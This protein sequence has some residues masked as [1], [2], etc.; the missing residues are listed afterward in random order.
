[1]KLREYQ[2]P[3]VNKL[4]RQLMNSNE[5]AL[6]SAVGTGKTLVTAVVGDELIKRG[7]VKKVIVSAP[8]NTIVKEFPQYT[9]KKILT[10]NANN[11][12]H[13]IGNIE[14]SENITHVCN[15]ILGGSTE[16]V[17]TSHH[18]M[19]NNKVKTAVNKAY[20]LSDLLLVIDEAHHC[21]ESDDEEDNSDGTLLGAIANKIK[22]KGG[23]ILYVTATPYRTV[24]NQTN[25]IFDP[26]KCKPVI[27]TIGEQMRDGYAPSMNTEY[28][29]VKDFSLTNA[30]DTGLFGDGFN[31]KIS[32][33]Q[34]H[35]LLPRIIKQWKTEG[36][37]K[38]ILLVPAGNA[39]HSASEVKKCIESIKFP[40]EI[41]KIRG[42]KYPSVL[43]SVGSSNTIITYDGQEMN[44]IEYDK[45][46]NGHAYD[47]VVGC[48]K[49][50]E[51]TDVSSA[52]HLYMVGLPSSVRLFHQRTGRVLRNKKSID[53]YAEWFGEQW[54]NLSKVVFF[55][56]VG[57]KT[58]D[59]DYKVGR[60]LLHCIF[61]AESYQE[62][63]E[64][65]N[66]SQNIRIAFEDK[67][68][69][70]KNEV[71]REQLDNIMTV[72]SGIELNELKDYS[73][74]E[75]DELVK[76][77][78]HPDMTIGE[79]LDMIK[80][81]SL[82]DEQRVIALNNLINHLPDDIKQNID[83]DKVVN[84][85][86]K[87]CKPKKVAGFDVAPIAVISSELEQVL[88]EF[89]N[90]KITT[91]KEKSI[92]KVFSELSGETLQE[93]AEKCSK[94]MGE[95]NAIMMCNKV[96]E[97]CNYHNGTYPV[98]KSH[99]E[100]EKRIGTWLRNMRSIKNGNDGCKGNFYPSLDKLA[101]EAGY[102]DM[103][104]LIDREQKAIQKI[105]EICDFI[106]V[107]NR[108]PVDSSSNDNERYLARALQGFRQS[109]SGNG[110]LIWYDIVQTIANSRGYS[111]IL[112]FIDD[113][114]NA[115]DITIAI[116]EFI[117]S[118]GKSPS[119][120][121]KNGIERK[122]GQQLT[123]MKKAKKGTGNRRIFYASVQ[124]KAIELGYPTLF[125]LIDLNETAN[126]R[127]SDICD[128]IDSN[129]RIPSNKS[130][131]AH[132][133]ALG[134]TL[135]NWKTA[136]KGKQSS[137][138]LYPSVIDIFT[139]RGYP[140]VLNGVD[141]EQ[142]ALDAVSEICDFIDIYKT[143]PVNSTNSRLSSKLIALRRAKYEQI[144]NGIRWYDS[145]QSLVESRGY[146]DMFNK[147]DNQQNAIDKLMK[148]IGFYKINNRLPTK[149]NIDVV[150]NQLGNWIQK[151]RKAKENN[152]GNSRLG[153]F[154]PILDSICADNGIPDLFNRIDRKQYQ[155]NMCTELIA[156]IKM[157]N[158]LPSFSSTN[159][160]EL[161]LARWIGTVRKGNEYINILSK[162]TSEV[163]YPN[164]FN[165][166]WKD[167][168][169]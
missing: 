153:I 32:D 71:T 63:C 31:T 95:D 15:L 25:L 56:P 94:F 143:Y 166:H 93:W 158:K 80:S 74:N 38:T 7:I 96:I 39:E 4:I 13:L 67:A 122:L 75:F 34:L 79:R 17:S 107:N 6:V 115:I 111:D 18:A 24:G 140:D 49:F 106:D 84:S 21:F 146:P 121:S 136:S 109:K 62:Y 105:T 98:Q 64:S 12:Q 30:G 156:H 167:D 145:I 61:A 138:I 58:K 144:P 76:E 59:F 157:Y 141:S 163:G 73:D 3:Q 132:E 55:A 159:K 103:F 23:K 135:S 165:K 77:S 65:M 130:S 81:A 112:N 47:I 108:T 120:N 151:Q 9:G 41:V 104:S 117:N 102:P 66:A 88:E 82:T 8:F 148:V 118:T 116:C 164:L 100:D 85:I 133:K 99:D 168:V 86:V 5:A 44:E 128:F 154:Y 142:R 113:E 14:K 127:A 26:L 137:C 1:M 50:D 68:K 162:M 89:C 97:F 139:S 123:D 48:R 70:E 43:I 169:K 114:Q 29:H 11:A 33:P 87:S 155:I 125:E 119:S 69:K 147:N 42:R 90:Q 37:P 131:D 51:G 27:R 134:Y 57:K 54:V 124:Q 20:D 22:E 101:I 52:S 160:T 72:L 40:S 36:Y 16:F 2:D 150:E 35:K 91:I 129:S 92:Q 161:S 126:K 149:S 110:K 10:G 83:W 45:A 19:A 46:V 28:V 53:G 152:G 60:Q 78:L